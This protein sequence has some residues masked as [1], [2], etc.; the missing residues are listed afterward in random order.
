MSS[1]SNYLVTGISFFVASTISMV[2]I[3][4]TNDRLSSVF[5]R[6]FI[7]AAKHL[8]ENCC[9]WILQQEQYVLKNL[10]TTLAKSKCSNILY[11]GMDA[12]DMGGNSSPQEATDNQ[13]IITWEIGRAHV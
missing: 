8:G 7:S 9:Y 12:A 11:K 6:D 13:S 10:T 5:Q 3:V 1:D 2:N 4:F